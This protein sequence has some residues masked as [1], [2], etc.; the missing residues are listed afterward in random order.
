MK[1]TSD[2]MA[3]VTAAFAEENK[4]AFLTHYPQC[5]PAFPALL[6][7]ESWSREGRQDVTFADKALWPLSETVYTLFF[8]FGGHAYRSEVFTYGVSVAGIRFTVDGE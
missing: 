7:P 6:N 2:Y 5:S 4:D 1:T 8:D 3:E